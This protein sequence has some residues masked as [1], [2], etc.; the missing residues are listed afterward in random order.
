MQINNEKYAKYKKYALIHTSGNDIEADDLVQDTLV[1]ILDKLSQNKLKPEQITDNLVFI[2]IKNRFLNN[3]S[4]DKVRNEINNKI[5]EE[6]VDYYYGDEDLNIPILQQQDN[7]IQNKLN[8]ISDIISKLPS[9]E[10]KLF[11]LHFIKGISQR[12]I[13]KETGIGIMPIFYRINKIKN[14]IKN[15]YNESK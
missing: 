13:S 10:Q 2:I 8:T 6:L 9:Y 3:K 7:I 1:Q 5:D 15:K 14:L 12:K 4:R 11:Y